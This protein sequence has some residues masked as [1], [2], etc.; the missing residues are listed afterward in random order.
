MWQNNAK[1]PVE[2]TWQISPLCD[3]LLLRSF[4]LDGPNNDAFVVTAEKVAIVQM[5]SRSKRLLDHNQVRDPCWASRC[6]DT[7]PRPDALGIWANMPAQ[8]A[9]AA[10]EATLALA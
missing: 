10:R 9:Q 2:N 3:M 7:L 8:S 6:A 4:V 1:A 5:F